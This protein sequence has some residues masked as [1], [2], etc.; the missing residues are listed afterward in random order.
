MVVG[1]AISFVPISKQEGKTAGGTIKEDGTFVMDTYGEGDGSIAGEFRVVVYQTTV[2]EPEAVIPDSDGSVTGKKFEPTSSEPIPIVSK[3]SQ[4][5][6]IYSDVV[7]SPI[8]VK[9][10]PDGEN[11]SLKIELKPM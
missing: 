5:P 1:G 8:T 3:A 2:Q 4:I 11:E 6:L 10:E 7:K 9:I